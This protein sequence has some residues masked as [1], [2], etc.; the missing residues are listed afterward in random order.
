M[1]EFV[2]RTL[3][4]AK[5]LYNN[6]CGGDYPEA[7]ILLANVISAISAKLWPGTG[8]DKKRF[9]ELCVRCEQPELGTKKISIPL[10][11]EDLYEK[12][13]HSGVAAIQKKFPKEF[14]GSPPNSGW[15]VITAKEVDSFENEVQKIC[16]S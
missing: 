3:D 14:M 6:Q 9:V 10:L 13:N 15:D 1:K 16:S 7:I 2:D 5:N 8:K 11:I 4:I 12:G